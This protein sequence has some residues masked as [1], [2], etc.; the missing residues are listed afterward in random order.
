MRA[1]HVLNF[2][3]YG[4]STALLGQWTR[5]LGVFTLEQA[6]HKLTFLVASIWGLEGRGLLRPGYAADIAVFDPDTVE[7]CEVEW[8]HDLPG[9]LKRLTQRA[10]GIH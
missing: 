2:A 1:A 10:V 3:T 9:G 5:E 7:P 8:A 4:Q 6:V